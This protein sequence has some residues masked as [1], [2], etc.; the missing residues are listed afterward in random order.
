MARKTKT[1]E[2]QPTIGKEGVADP[3]DLLLHSNHK[4]LVGLEIS[5]TADIIQNCFSQ[6]ALEQILA[7]QVGHH[8]PRQLKKV[9]QSLEDATVR[10]VNGDVCIP[11]SGLKKAMQT[12]ARFDKSIKQGMLKYNCYVEGQSIPL[13]FSDMVPRMDPVRLHSVSGTTTDIRF[14]PSFV[15][16]SARMVLSFN[17]KQLSAQMVVDLLNEAG[18]IGVGEWRPEK[19]GTYGTFEVTRA[20]G[21]PE[22]AEV[23]TNCAPALKPLIIPEWALDAEIDPKLLAKLLASDDHHEGDKVEEPANPDEVAAQ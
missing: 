6:K 14:R 13:A 16:W 15:L 3:G 5:G 4:S 18:R 12:A 9:S 20:F 8:M 17:P 1:A 19:N 2:E 11:P 23:R 10:N 7:K 22:I 21:E